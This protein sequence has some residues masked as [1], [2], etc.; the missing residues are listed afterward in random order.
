[1]ARS[2]RL[3]ARIH[4]A[5]AALDGEADE[6]TLATVAPPV[7]RG[8]ADQP[9]RATATPQKSWH[10][11]SSGN[12]FEASRRQREAGPTVG[13][14]PKLLVALAH[15]HPAVMTWGQVAAIAGLKA[16]GGHFNA[17]CKWLRAKGYIVED[18]DGLTL[19]SAGGVAAGIGPTRKGEPDAGR[20]A[21]APV[22]GA[23]GPGS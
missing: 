11:T 16:R 13:A 17:G 8:P 21:R 6:T 20:L 19:S 3:R 4:A 1:M 14:G 7:V 23:A 15:V 9:R 2:E 5:R 10:E 22:R 12:G 18:G